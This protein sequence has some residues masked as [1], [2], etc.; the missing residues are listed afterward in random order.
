MRVA[1][2]RGVADQAGVGVDATAFP[3][4]AAFIERMFARPSVKALL[5]EETPMWAMKRG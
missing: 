4:L 5:D 2:G 1:V 3:R